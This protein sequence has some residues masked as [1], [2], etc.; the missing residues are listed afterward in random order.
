MVGLS[1]R[2]TSCTKA[3]FRTSTE[4][5]ADCEAEDS[6]AAADTEMASGCSTVVVPDGGGDSAPAV[7]ATGAT[8]TL[9][10]SAKGPGSAAAGGGGGGGGGE[11][12]TESTAFSGA[13][14]IFSGSCAATS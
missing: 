6:A 3:R 9:H 8:A 10:S 4:A 7:D 2:R 13:R 14:E 11:T 12:D 1:G 5:A